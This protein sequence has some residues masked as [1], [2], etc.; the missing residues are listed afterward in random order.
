M[1]MGRVCCS[2]NNQG[3]NQYSRYAKKS[4]INGACNSLRAAK[5]VC[6][7]KIKLESNIPKMT[8]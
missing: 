1:R 3:L 4:A 2:L 7:S 8:W 5:I 6:A